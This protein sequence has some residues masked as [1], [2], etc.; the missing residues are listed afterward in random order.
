MDKLLRWCASNHELVPPEGA[1]MQREDALI[2]Y[3]RAKI[4][5]LTG[6]E[7]QKR[8]AKFI[9]DLYHVSASAKIEHVL[10]SSLARRQAARSLLSPNLQGADHQDYLLE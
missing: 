3:R 7:K 2:P 1:V 4:A 9:Y 8:K 5:D 6:V 10:M